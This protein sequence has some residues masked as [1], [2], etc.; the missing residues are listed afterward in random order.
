LELY[1][2]HHAHPNKGEW[3]IKAPIGEH[4]L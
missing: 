1:R 2:Q 3:P 4:R